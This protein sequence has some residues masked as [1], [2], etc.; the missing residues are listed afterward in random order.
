MDLVI[1]H[2]S[3][4]GWGW[5]VALCVL[6]VGAGGGRCRVQPELLFFHFLWKNRCSG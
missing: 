4:S 3:C 2:Q 5:G 1:E 6:G